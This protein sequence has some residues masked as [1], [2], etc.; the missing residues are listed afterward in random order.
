MCLGLSRPTLPSTAATKGTLFQCAKSCDGPY[1]LL[2][3]QGVSSTGLP[4]SVY[5]K[6]YCKTHAG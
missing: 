4:L 2:C 3:D 5:K 1:L 6:S